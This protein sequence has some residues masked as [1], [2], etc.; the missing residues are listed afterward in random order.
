[1]ASAKG[2][3]LGLQIPVVGVRSLAALAAAG[4][5]VAEPQ[6]QVVAAVIDA[7]RGELFYGAYD[8]SGQVAL[9]AGHALVAEIEQALQPCLGRPEV[10]L[11]GKQAEMLPGARRLRG[12]G[13]E[14][15]DA[16]WIAHCAAAQLAAG[17]PPASDSVEPVYLRAP[18]ATPPAKHREP[19]P[20]VI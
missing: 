3:A 13:C 20:R 10:A 1:M 19:R 6:V 8:R 16:E 2:M 15:P 5:A 11:V 17:V 12:P 7:K 14:L 18:D 9:A 4:F